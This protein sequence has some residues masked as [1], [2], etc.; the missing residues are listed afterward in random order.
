MASTTADRLTLLQ[1][2]IRQTLHSRARTPE[3]DADIAR[4]L[5]TLHAGIEQLE[6]EQQQLEEHGD[7]TSQVLRERED[8]LIRLRTQHD[9]L[10]SL[11]THPPSSPSSPAP[12]PTATPTHPAATLRRSPSADTAA[13]EALMGPRETPSALRKTVRFSDL[14]NTQVL[15]LHQR[16]MEEQDEDL[17]RLSVS[18]RN[19]RELSIQIG[20]ELEGHVQLLDGVDELVERHTERLGGARRGLGVVERGVREN[21]SLVVIVVLIVVL[22]VL[23]AVLKW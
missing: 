21:G 6:K 23:I 10:H 22:V 2:H 19:Q 13:R 11:F 4:S 14:D 9:D 7:S 18:I 5:S 17:D 15:Q 1:D 8:I 3:S 20:D 16:V 12:T